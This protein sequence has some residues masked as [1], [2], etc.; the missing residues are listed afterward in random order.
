MAAD[1]YAIVIGI[2]TYP[3]FGETIADP[4]NLEAPDDDA[5]AVCKWL[6]DKAGGDVPLTQIDVVRTSQPAPGAGALWPNKQAVLDAFSRLET[7]AQN[8]ELAGKGL[9]VG[10]RLYV[11]AS[12]HGF[13]SRRKEGALFVADATKIQTNHIFASR[14]VEWFA[15]ADY[16]AEVVLWMDCCMVSD[17]SILPETAGYRVLT[18]ATG[19]SQ[20]FTA[21]AARYPLQA[22][23]RP[24]PAGPYRG[25]FTRA[26]LEALNG[27]NAEPGTGNVTSQTV[28]D[29][30]TNT[31]RTYMTATD[32]TD[33]LISK[34]PDFGADDPIVFCS[35]PSG[36]QTV[37]LVN[38]PAALEGQ[39]CSILTGAPP[40]EA[41][42][43]AV[44][45]GALQCQLGAG[46]YF[47]R[48]AGFT[49]GFEVPGGQH[50]RIDIA[51]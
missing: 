19:G 24:T 20:M 5:D 2:K 46:I 49:H 15:N 11:Y 43:G 16:F 22:V 51:V 8:N 9:R 31:M 50:V 40:R 45:K 21:Y 25:V 36:L 4:R 29:Y 37:D 30:V 48:A 6:L 1:D 34:E 27:A 47:A 13:A 39:P 35:R 17:L 33:D 14:W 10:R 23:E 41:A 12:G 42:K 26:L 18:N 38:F 28:R 3:R 7:I 32:L 44:T